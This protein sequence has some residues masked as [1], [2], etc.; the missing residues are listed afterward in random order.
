MLACSSIS[1]AENC[2]SQIGHWT[3]EGGGGELSGE[4]THSTDSEEDEEVG[5]AGWGGELS[6][7]VAA[8]R[9]RASILKEPEEER[10]QLTWACS[11]AE[12]SVCCHSATACSENLPWLSISNPRDTIICLPDIHQTCTRCRGIWLSLQNIKSIGKGQP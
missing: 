5:E 4:D 11:Q 1:L 2:S 7:Q 8:C 3:Q 10:G 9:G 12:G 6:P